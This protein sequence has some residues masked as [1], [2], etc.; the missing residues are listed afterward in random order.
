[1]KID[2]ANTCHKCLFKDSCPFF[3]KAANLDY[4]NIAS[5]LL[6]YS[7]ALNDCHQT[8]KI[9]HRHWSSGYKLI[10]SIAI[11]FDLLAQGGQE[12]E[13]YNQIRLDLLKKSIDSFEQ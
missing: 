13:E 7:Q 1:M 10:D 3:K 4:S 11:S 5:D 2:E 6:I 8:D 9:N 12:I